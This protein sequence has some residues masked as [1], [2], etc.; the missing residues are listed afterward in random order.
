M[1][2]IFTVTN[3][4]T[5]DQR[6]TRICSSLANAGH[7]I[8]LVG[9]KRKNSTQFEER[10]Y[11]QK[12]LDVIMQK[13][14]GFYSLFNI[15]LFFYLLFKKCDAI[16]CIDLDTMPAVY[17]ATAIKKKIRIYDAHEYFSQLKEVITRPRVY[18]VWHFIEKKMVPAFK[19]GYT[20]SESIADEFQ[21]LY[22]VNYLTIR[23]APLLKEYEHKI[24]NA[25]LIYYQGSVNEGRCFEMLIPAM[26]YVN[27]EMV[28]YGDGNF[29]A[30]TQQLIKENNLEHKVITKGKIN[31]EELELTIADAYIGINLVEPVGL[32]Q[33]YSLANKFFDYIHHNIPQVTMKFPE[34]EKINNQYEV[35]L[36]IDNCT[37]E[38]IAEAI[39]KLLDNE[40][41]YARL[42][43]N[44][45]DAKKV[46]NWQE[47]ERKLISFYQ[48]IN[49]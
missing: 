21:K 33:Y 48:S 25:K 28:I 46:Y 17:F 36:L 11:L 43:N 40:E 6:M 14:F 8:L 19:L 39:N 22:H 16:C 2:I 42:A 20:V 44:C 37:V 30:Q 18:K 31:P 4:L 26:K 10:K 15:H 45:N 3:D 12:R 23:N 7:Q 38:C 27:T 9:V 24:K 34:Y 29:M 32:N 49:G 13:G 5:Y 41:L 35:A 47:E 1:R